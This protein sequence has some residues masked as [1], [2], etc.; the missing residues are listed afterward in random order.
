MIRIR[1]AHIH[2]LKNI[3]VDIP[4]GKLTVITGVS[5][6]GK[7][8]LAF[9]TIYE[10]GK[11]RYL[12]YVGSLLQIDEHQTFD[13]ITG[14]SPT[15]AVEQRIIRQN[16]PRSTLGTRTR[17]NNLLQMLFSVAGVF[18]CPACG[19]KVDASRICIGCG[20]VHEPYAS[21]FYSRNSAVGF[22][23]G[24]LGTGY[25]AEIG[26]DEVFKNPATPIGK[27]LH[28]TPNI[29]HRLITQLPDF[30]RAYSLKETDP[31]VSLSR[32]AR[33]A[34]LYGSEKTTFEGIIAYVRHNGMVKPVASRLPLVVRAGMGRVITCPDCG[35]T[36]LGE[37]A[38]HTAVGGRHIGEMGELAVTELQSNLA[39]CLGEG[40]IDR[41]YGYLVDAINRRLVHLSEVGLGYLTL[42][43]ATPT[44]SG[45][46]LQRM[47]LASYLI[48]SLDSVIFVFDEPTIGLHEVEKGLLLKKLRELVQAGNTVIVV[49]HDPGIIAAA[50]YIVDLGP[51]A[52][53]RGG[54]LIFA[55]DY[56]GFLQCEASSS[57]A[58]LTGKRPMP[59]RR[60]RL[61]GSSH[62][63]GKTLVIRNA[64]THNLKDITVE[65]PLGV[66]VGVAG[67]S[68]SGKSSLVA[69]TLVAAWNAVALQAGPGEREEEEDEGGESFF[70]TYQVGRIEG[71]G[72]ISR[73]AV[74][75]QKPIGRMSTSNPASYIGVYDR[76]RQIFAAQPLA[77][78][79]GYRPGHFTVN[80][81][82]GCV[83]CRG[84][85][86]LYTYV[87]Y[88]NVI[89]RSCES[90]GGS[91]FNPEVLDVR[92]EGRTICD[93]LNLTVSEAL[94]LFAKEPKITGL[95]SVLERTGMGYITLGQPATTISG[96][97]AQRIK[98]AKEL[99]RRSRQNVL[100]ILDE[101]TTG[102]SLADTARLMEV[103]DEL[104]ERGNSVLF[105]EHDPTMLAFCDWLIELG[106]GGGNEG[107]WVI[108]AGTPGDLISNPRSVIGRYL[109]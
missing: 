19:G 11:R 49:E 65:I 66:L 87:G 88:G 98:L 39:A 100:Y 106:P 99:G 97:E 44:I 34:F 16:N 54:R 23:F 1:N 36:G 84:K 55:G 12:Q 28:V 32:E 86:I 3:N 92:F 26:E 101:P 75:S 20:A 61:D 70:P 37:V 95:L 77:V 9:D 56:P 10:E 40:R 15:L 21:S 4:K 83:K 51:G 6:S 58:Y 74:I 17:I 79:R 76:I 96:G 104:V 14:L 42:S 30:Y 52:G 47:F 50:D 89:S 81:E 108:A 72:H 46:E 109:K 45:G 90:C 107:G 82:G 41:K 64:C 94:D 85:G 60:G 38:R 53:T 57:A 2:N 48:S 24:C 18:P 68:G 102:L 73:C 103:L 8:S 105:T 43:R 25:R 13:E 5:G 69:D 91:G 29:F 33:D 27:M 63:L 78:E 71:I 80:G 22:C 59:A 35:G 67:V 93:V 7:S 31:C 62:G